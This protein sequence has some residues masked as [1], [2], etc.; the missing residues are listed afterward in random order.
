MKNEEEGRR[1]AV[2]DLT[3][4]HDGFYLTSTNHCIHLV[5]QK[6]MPRLVG[7]GTGDGERERGRERG[8]GVC[9]VHAYGHVSVHA[10]AHTQIQRRTESIMLY[11]FLSASF[12]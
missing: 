2:L 3:G 9:A 1:A 12:P 7:C 11:Y 10:Y 6:G 8:G 5:I 4:S